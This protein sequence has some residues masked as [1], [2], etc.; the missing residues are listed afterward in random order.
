MTNKVDYWKDF[1]SDKKDPL[2][3]C[4]DK[5]YY[6]NYGNELSV[7][8]PEKNITSILE[9][10]CGSGSLYEPLGFNKAI[11]YV[12]VDL[13]QSMLD[14]FHL[15]HANLALFQDSADAYKD[16]NKYDLIFTNGLIQYLSLKMLKKQLRNALEML[17]NEGVIIHSSIPWDIMKKQY[18]TGNLMPP[19]AGS[20]IKKQL[21]Y[22]M[23]YLGIKEDSMGRWYSINDFR[24]IAN[25]FNLEAD[26]FGSMYYP[27]RF[28]V[29]L[30]K[31]N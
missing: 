2:H 19:Y 27:Y 1:W 20:T 30:K 24:K 13:S 25:E 12:G 6:K 5:N 23:L 11:S 28:H 10:G 3:T 4:S 18:I 7:L 15:T 16:D 29:V 22:W 9:L 14:E 31:Y 26:F 17:N 8:L 21:L